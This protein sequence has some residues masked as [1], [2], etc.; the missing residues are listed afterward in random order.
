[1]QMR[2]PRQCRRR[3]TSVPLAWLLHDVQPDVTVPPGRRPMMHTVQDV[4]GIPPAL[5]R[6]LAHTILAE[7]RGVEPVDG[8]T[9]P[10]A[11]AATLTSVVD[12]LRSQ[13]ARASEVLLAVED[14]FA[15]LLAGQRD[16]N[17]RGRVRAL[18]GHAR[19][20]VAARLGYGCD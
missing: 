4:V 10:A 11:L 14:A 19:Q 3:L 13:G 9:P 20:V 6:A 18:D 16:A 1:M 17:G 7:V 8:D 5:D 12:A 15:A 2:Y